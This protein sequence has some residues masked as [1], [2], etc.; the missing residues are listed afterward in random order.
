MGNAVGLINVTR[1]GKLVLNEGVKM[2]PGR[3]YTMI[4]EA[5]DSGKKTVGF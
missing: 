2:E 1:D 3:N 4:V 5:S